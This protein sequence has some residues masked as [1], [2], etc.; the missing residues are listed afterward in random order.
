MSRLD[1]EAAYARLII[2]TGRAWR[3]VADRALSQFPVSASTAWAL[4]QLSRMGDEARQVDLARELDITSASTVR[5]IDQLARD[6]LVLRTPDPTD[7]RATR[8]ALTDQGRAMM[9]DIEAAL[10]RIRH[11]VLAG[12][13]DDQIAAAVAVA[14]QVEARLAGQKGV[15]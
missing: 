8:L 5:L 12:L 3:Q 15:A 1:H 7:R 14:R 13:S 11:D 6:G 9:A 2:S 10:A 4:V